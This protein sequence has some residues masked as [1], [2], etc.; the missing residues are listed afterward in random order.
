MSDP[1]V[2]YVVDQGWRPAL[3][4]RGTKYA[5]CVIADS[6]SISV[7]RVPL[8]E[9]EASPRV[10]H[11]G[12]PYSP[13]KA[14]ERFLAASRRRHQRLTATREAMRIIRITLG[15]PPDPEPPP[16]EDPPG[17]TGAKDEPAVRRS[18]G[19]LRD[20]C[21]ELSI[22]PATARRMLRAAGLRAPYGDVPAIRRVLTPSN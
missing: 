22:E 7:L 1:E 18:N 15:L 13:L 5:S 11:L 4:L 2:R 6:T 10:P 21:A 8:R 16:P 9:F 14:A 20:I 19:P 17:D 12:G 3:C